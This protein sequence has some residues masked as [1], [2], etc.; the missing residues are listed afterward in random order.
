MGGGAIGRIHDGDLIRIAVDR[1][2][3]EGSIDM[4]GPEGVDVG[5]EGGARLLAE[6]SP[7]P[8]LSPDP[9]LPDDVRLWAALQEAS[10]G[11]WG[12]CV[13]DVEAILAAMGRA[14]G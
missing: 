14:G 11:V 9:D 4:V 8:R 2:R 6:R 7:H 10:G 1:V 13:Y 5:P 12:G 3:L